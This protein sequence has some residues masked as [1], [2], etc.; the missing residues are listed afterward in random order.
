[1]NTQKIYRKIK[2]GFGFRYLAVLTVLALVSFSCEG[3]EGPQG[4]EGSQGPGTNWQII[5]VSV[6]SSDWV[7]HTD[8]NNAV[9]Y[10]ASVSVPEI[11]NFIYDSGTVLNYID[12]NGS[13]Q[14]LPY[15]LH[16]KDA[17]NNYWTRT[18]DSDFLVGQVNYYVT[19]SD[20]FDEVPSTMNFR[21]VLMW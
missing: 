10:S 14:I 3:P 7:R 17:N 13:Q 6:K 9:Y 8:A 12:F 4:P 19:N 16:Q 18:I 2:Q 5:K 20:F 21:I 15:V 1:M 11:T